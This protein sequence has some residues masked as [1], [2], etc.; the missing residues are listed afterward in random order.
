MESTVNDQL[1]V[2]CLIT[3]LLVKLNWLL[4]P[5]WVVIG[6]YIVGRH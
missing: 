1:S 2:Q 3:A 4:I 6:N 5:T